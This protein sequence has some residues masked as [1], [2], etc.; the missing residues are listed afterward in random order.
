MIHFTCDRCQREIDPDVE[1]RYV[2]RMEIQGVVEPNDLNEEDD[3]D[4]LHEVEDMI[5]RL[6]EQEEL[7]EDIYHRQRFDLCPKCYR[8]FKKN[9]LAREALPQLNFS[10]N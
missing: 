2:V 7:G 6:D 1:L 9:P 5:E 10:K 3:R 4:Y 8:K